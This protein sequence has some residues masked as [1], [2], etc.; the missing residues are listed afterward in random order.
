MASPDKHTSS[1]IAAKNWAEGAAL[2]TMRSS[3]SMAKQASVEA[4]G[5]DIARMSPARAGPFAQHLA[6]RLLASDAYT[7]TLT[8]KHADTHTHRHLNDL[9]HVRP[10]GHTDAREFTAPDIQSNTADF[11]AH[12]TLD[13]DVRPAHLCT[14][15]RKHTNKCERTG[16]QGNVPCMINMLGS[17][18]P[19]PPHIGIASTLC[20]HPTATRRTNAPS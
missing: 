13:I 14:A 12:S 6:D 15:G 20:V 1:I 4:V 17:T 10:L 11:A 19:L 2:E 3:A 18:V 5:G 16:Q 9:H 7:D 8:H